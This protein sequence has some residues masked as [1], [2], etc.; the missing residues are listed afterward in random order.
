MQMAVIKIKIPNQY[1]TKSLLGLSPHSSDLRWWHFKT[2]YTHSARGKN[3]KAQ[4]DFMLFL[5]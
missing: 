2:N 5:C 4:A 1:P 3:C